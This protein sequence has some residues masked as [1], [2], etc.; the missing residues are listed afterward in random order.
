MGEERR[1]TKKMSKYERIEEIIQAAVDE[2]LE[3]GYDGTSMEAI[4]RRAG[5]SKG[6]LYHHFSSKDEIL[7]FANQKLNE[8]VV[9]IMIEAA[10]K[11]SA[12]DGLLW[13][14]QN[15]L[16]YWKGH[17]KEMVF[18]ILSFAKLIDN[19]SLWQMYENYTEK[20]LSFIQKLYQGGIDSGEFVPHSAYESALTFMSAVDGVVIYLM[21]DKNLNLEKVV[22]TFQERFVRKFQRKSQMQQKS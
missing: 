13:Y 17:R 16:E 5:I 15:Y 2:F 4:A 21:V 22:S 10:Q 9:E 7:L 8:P 3:C 20:T 12:I 1:M 14:I 6:G 18:Y 19:P 11:P